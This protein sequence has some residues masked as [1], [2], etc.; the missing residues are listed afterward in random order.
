MCFPTPGCA[1]KKQHGGREYDN[2]QNWLRKTLYTVYSFHYTINWYKTNSFKDV[3]TLTFQN[4]K[5]ERVIFQYNV[6]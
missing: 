1:E 5:R 2:L 4:E 3:P 6:V